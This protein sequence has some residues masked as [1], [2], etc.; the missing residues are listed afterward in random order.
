METQ[1]TLRVNRLTDIKFIKGGAVQYIHEV[2]KKTPNF[3]MNLVCGA[4]PIDRGNRRLP[5]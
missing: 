1:S 3:K 4:A 5:S 2:H